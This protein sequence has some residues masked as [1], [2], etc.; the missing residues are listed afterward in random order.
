MLFEISQFRFDTLEPTE[1]PKRKRGRPLKAE[2]NF[3]K[4]IEQEM[5]R[6]GM[7]SVGDVLLESYARWVL[8]NGPNIVY[9]DDGSEPYRVDPP[10]LDS[11]A[12][13]KRTTKSANTRRESQK[14]V[15]EK[16]KAEYPKYWKMRRGGCVEIASKLNAK[17]NEKLEQLG[18]S[19]M[20]MKELRKLKKDLGLI[21]PDTRTIRRL[22]KLY[23]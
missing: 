9:P 21:T 8:S 1:I 23:P 15:A 17:A 13:Q 16:L 10:P 4:R 11:V 18:G 2:A 7:L 5:A 22:K 19:H 12:H 20:E 3:R 6:R 14:K